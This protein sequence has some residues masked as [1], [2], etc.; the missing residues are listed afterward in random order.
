M[1]CAML[2][3]IRP[4]S[5]IAVV[6]P[7]GPVSLELY[8]AG[9]SILAARYNLV[10]CHDPLF[11]SSRDLPY[12]ADVDLRRAESF[13]QAL[14]DERVEAIFCGRGGYGTMRLLDDLDGE[15]LQRRRPLII[16]FSDITTLHAWAAG[17]GVPTVHGPVVTQLGRLPSSEIQ[18]LFDLLEGTRLPRLS[19][20]EGLRGGRASGPLFGGNLTVLSHLCGTP[21]LP[22]L[23][24]HILLLEEIDEAPYRIDRMLTQLRLAGVLQKLSGI[25]VGDLLRCDAPQGVPP[26]MVRA[27]AVVEERLGDLG[28]P[29]VFHAPVGHGDHNVAL[30]LGVSADLDANAGTLCFGG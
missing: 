4:G 17:L 15:A 1:A 12:L 18:S 30:P 22:D 2:S 3:N 6:A 9:L 16:G 23:A 29:M 20:L 10:H 28:I 26:T 7:A 27:R 24:G 11:P 13:N 21:Y 5:Q 25:V 14:R 8:R 19:G